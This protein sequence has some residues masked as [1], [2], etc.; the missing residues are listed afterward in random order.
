MTNAVLGAPISAG[1]P[2]AQT[3]RIGAL[4]RYFAT[5]AALAL[6]SFAAG[7]R[8][9]AAVNVGDYPYLDQARLLAN[10][11]REINESALGPAWTPF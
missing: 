7:F 6:G 11:Q 3:S 8:D 1:W 9:D 4:V 5:E 2:Y 10:L